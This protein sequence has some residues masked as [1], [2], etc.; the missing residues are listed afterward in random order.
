MIIRIATCATAI[1]LA[2]ASPAYAEIITVEY[3]A[4][5]GDAPAWP[6]GTTVRGV[7][8]FDSAAVGV[9]ELATPNVVNYPALSHTIELTEGSVV[10]V[11]N[12]F[13]NPQLVV[14]NDIGCAGGLRD[15]IDAT[16]A[17]L[18]GST[19][20]GRV[21]FNWATTL[22]SCGLPNDDFINTSLPLNNDDI[23]GFSLPADARLQ[24]T[25]RWIDETGN[26]RVNATVGAITSYN[27]V[28]EDETL[29][30]TCEGFKFPFAKPV[31][32][33]RKVF[34]P[35]LL[36]A[37]L[38]DEGAVDLGPETLTAPPV[39]SVSYNGTFQGGADPNTFVASV[40]RPTEGNTFV[41]N[42]ASTTRIR[43]DVNE[44]Q[45]A[46]NTKPYSQPGTYTVSVMPG[47]ASYAISPTCSQSFVRK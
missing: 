24:I 32:L 34:L 35:I 45:F 26:D 10:G 20:N 11:M 31:T 6:A 16:G 18:S 37:N 3:E 8:T 14:I 9:P 19:F 22:L 13:F 21:I 30:V 36:R 41:W 46:L 2:L 25:Y 7:Y 12:A 4:T 42:D 23:S 17:P 1:L 40:L 44:W 33:P 27:F 47:D 39:V 28:E 38:V 15:R 29:H 5:L 43:T